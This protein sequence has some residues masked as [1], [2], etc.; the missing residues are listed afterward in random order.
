MKR[1]IEDILKENER[2]EAELAKMAHRYEVAHETVAQLQAI[3][4]EFK[5]QVRGCPHREFN[6]G[7][8]VE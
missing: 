2:L 6:C 8:C 1:S 3:I 4:Q 7:V 5:D